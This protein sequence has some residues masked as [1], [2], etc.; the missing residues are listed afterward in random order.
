MVR[1][2]YGPD[3]W[4][5]PD[6]TQQSG[7]SGDQSDDGRYDDGDRYDD[8]RYGTDTDRY[9]TEADRYGSDEDRYRQDTGSVPGPDQTGQGRQRRSSDG[10]DR[11]DRHNQAGRPQGRNLP[12]GSR[13][14]SSRRGRRSRR[15]S[16][17]SYVLSWVVVVAAI[18]VILVAVG[19]ALV[20][21]DSDE[22]SLFAGSPSLSSSSFLL[23]TWPM[24]GMP[25]NG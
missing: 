23:P 14:S 11:G 22:S 20:G 13:G 18:I 12:R 1:K 3:Y 10:R 24:D 19:D 2:E 5:Q 8:D 25:T 16:R 21:M 7:Q 15:R 17:A 9:G 4:S 6:D